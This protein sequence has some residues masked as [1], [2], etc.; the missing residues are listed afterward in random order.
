MR[1][2]NRDAISVDLSACFMPKVCT[3]I[4]LDNLFTVF[5]SLV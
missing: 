5:T 4:C 3:K 2:V 1:R